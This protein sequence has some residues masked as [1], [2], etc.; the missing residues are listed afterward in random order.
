MDTQEQLA[1]AVK[2][3]AVE[4]N[5]RLVLSC[6]QAFDLARKTGAD[7][8][9]VAGICNEEQIKIVGCQLGCF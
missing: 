5:G 9:A 7:L 6:P 1:E 8:N 4:R 2:Q 3:A